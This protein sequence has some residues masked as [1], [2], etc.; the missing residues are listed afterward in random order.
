[1]EPTAGLIAFETFD[2]TPQGREI[3]YIQDEFSK[4]Y[5]TG[6]VESTQFKAGLGKVIYFNYDPGRTKGVFLAT[7][8]YLSGR[9]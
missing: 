2:V 3:A 7:L 8:E 5:Y 1:S 4:K 9:R 6:I